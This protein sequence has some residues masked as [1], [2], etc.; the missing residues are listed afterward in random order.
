M[1]A[2]IFILFSGLQNPILLVLSF[3]LTLFQLRPLGA[4][5][6]WFLFFPRALHLFLSTFLLPAAKRCSRL[7]LCIPSPAQNQP[8]LQGTFV[9]FIDVWYLKPNLGSRCAQLLLACHC[10]Y[11]L[12]GVR[13]RKYVYIHQS[14]RKHSSILSSV[15]IYDTT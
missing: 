14:K 3:L 13:A 10:F 8:L 12:S 15:S 5:S 6:S 11:A 1:N 2:W 9:S 7:T 4:L